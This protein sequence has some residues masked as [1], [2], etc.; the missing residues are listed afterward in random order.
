MNA[1][2]TPL[3]LTQRLPIC[4]WTVGLALALIFIS[5]VPA[6]AHG[7]GGLLRIDGAALGPYTVMIWT[8]PSILRPGEVHVETAVWRGRG[9]V[10][11]CQVEVSITPLDAREQPLH[12]AAGTPNAATEFRHEAAFQLDRPGRYAVSVSVRDSLARGGDATFEVAISPLSGLL[13]GFIYLQVAIAT[14][15]GIWV[16]KTG[17]EFIQRSL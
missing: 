2:K 3:S 8:S 14:V 17:A 9:A 1:G 13:R 10:I 12:I 5:Y 16:V 7:S 15:A 4:I 6:V 11:N